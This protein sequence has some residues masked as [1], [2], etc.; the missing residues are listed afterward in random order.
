[1]LESELRAAPQELARIFVH[2]LFHFAWARLG[3][4]RRRSYEQ[5]LRGE[6]AA[7]AR[8]ELGWSAQERKLGL[9]GVEKGPEW[10]AYVCESFCDTAAY[11]YAGCERH[12]EFTLRPKWRQKRTLWFDESL[13]GRP[14]SI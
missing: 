4:R 9:N 6:F 5:L 14:L 3:N 10:R 13:G 12:E 11:L 2:E 7:H 1:V 8:G